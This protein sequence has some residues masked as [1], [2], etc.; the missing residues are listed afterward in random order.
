MTEVEGDDVE[1]RERNCE[2]AEE[3]VAHCQIR[4]E[5][6]SRCQHVLKQSDFT[7]VVVVVNFGSIFVSTYLATLLVANAARTA[8]LAKSPTAKMTPYMMMKQY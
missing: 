2:Q 1:E 6:V 4:D 7:V 5:D 3:D 8:T